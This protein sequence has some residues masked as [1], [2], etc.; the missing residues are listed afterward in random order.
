MTPNE[1]QS[2][3]SSGSLAVGTILD[4]RYEIVSRIGA[5]GMGEVFR[6]RDRKL[7][8]WRCIKT[9]KPSLAANPRFLARFLREARIARGIEHPNIARVHELVL[10]ER[11]PYLVAEL[12]EGQTL[13]EWLIEHGAM[14]VSL[15]C[16]VAS[17]VLAGL[18]HLH[19]R[20]LL[21]RDIAF[22][23]VML[24]GDAEDV[25]VKIIDL[26]ITKEVDP[27]GVAM[28]QSGVLIGNPRSMS[29]EQLGAL[30]EGETIDGRS[31]LYSLGL[32]LYELLT[33]VPPF[34]SETSHG[35]V[36]LH[37]TQTPPRFATV[38]PGLAIPQ[39]VEHVVLRALEKDRR[40]RYAGLSPARGARHARP[41][42]EWP[43]R[44]ARSQS[45]AASA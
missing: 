10:H 37:L 19:D 6:A 21:H 28:T 36:A 17:Q 8:V 40:R 11:G 4:D 14:P 30:G 13:G 24:A 42:A 5:G 38:R 3:N 26:G 7:E 34:S 43:G 22:G 33:G 27:T 18:A 41:S 23:N 35:F 12:I 25:T 44:A 2:Q 29:P 1:R 31:D 9:V 15:A 32:V 45:A 20:G 39:K 16:E